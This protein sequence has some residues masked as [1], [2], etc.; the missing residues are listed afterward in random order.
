MSAFGA[1]RT[2]AP[3]IQRMFLLASICP[4]R[5]SKEYRSASFKSAL[6]RIGDRWRMSQPSHLAKISGKSITAAG[7][8]IAVTGLVLASASA[9]L[10]V[11][12]VKSLSL[13]ELR[14][15]V[16]GEV[17]A[18]I[19]DV[20]RSTRSDD[21]S[22]PVRYMDFYTRAHIGNTFGLCEAKRL[23]VFFD[24]TGVPHDIGML[25]IYG[26]AGQFKAEQPFPSTYNFH[27]EYDKQDK[28]CAAAT[29]VHKYLFAT[30]YKRAVLS[31]RA[32][33]LISDSYERGHAPNFAFSCKLAHADCSTGKERD[34]ILSQIKVDNI[35]AAGPTDCKTH[36]SPVKEEFYPNGCFDIVLRMSPEMA[37]DLFIETEYGPDSAIRVKSVKF[38]EI[39]P[40]RRR[41]S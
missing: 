16:F 17:G 25:D 2:R 4:V 20:G 3:P 31:A 24:E 19:V 23:Q 22:K 27:E 35:D 21:P 15:E 7:W 11:G 29:D 1:K 36:L 41:P 34:M 5:L 8:G 38:R 6:N 9:A 30:T 28:I 32:V 14:K 10:T 33:K 12:Q 37:D 13:P 26:D 18:M 39:T 40:R